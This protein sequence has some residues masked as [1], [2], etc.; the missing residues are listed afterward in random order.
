MTSPDTSRTP[1]QGA[2]SFPGRATPL[3]RISQPRSEDPDVMFVESAFFREPKE[4]WPASSA[5]ENTGFGQY[6]S[7]ESLFEAV[8]EL[9]E[10]PDRD[11]GP[12]AV[13]GLTRRATWEE[14][15]KAHRRL[16]S[17]LHPDRYVDAD[18][19]VRDA[20]E[21]RVRDVNE[22]YSEIRRERAGAR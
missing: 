22:A 5:L 9:F 21:R 16:V 3:P 6:Y 13:L 14:I 8:P 7:T 17:E 10:E 11:E 1:E 15:S 20:A 4:Q 19:V 2:R 18:D 12:Y